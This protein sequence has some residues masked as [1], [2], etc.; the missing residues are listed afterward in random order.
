[1][2]SEQDRPGENSTAMRPT[3][4]GTPFLVRASV[5]TSKRIHDLASTNG[6]SDTDVFKMGIALLDVFTQAKQAGNRLV[7]VDEQGN[8]VQE[9]KGP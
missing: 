1:M 7:V 9:I 4:A 6:V 5:H 8:I 2:G 3:Q